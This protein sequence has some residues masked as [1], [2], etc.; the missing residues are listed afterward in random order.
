MTEEELEDPRALAAVVAGAP[1]S[2]ANEAKTRAMLLKAAHDM[3]ARY[4]TTLWEDEEAI[5]RAAEE[6]AYPSADARR[7][8][9]LRAREKETLLASATLVLE[10]LSPRLS[11][12]T[13]EERYVEARKVEAC[14]RRATGEAFDVFE[15]PPA[16]NGGDDESESESEGESE[17]AR[18]GDDAAKEEL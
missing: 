15:E 7:A 3:L 14:L 11:E 6:E 4:P 9:W 10:Q 1:A 2:D 17:S 8:T 12:E 5:R 18:G 13:C 16:R